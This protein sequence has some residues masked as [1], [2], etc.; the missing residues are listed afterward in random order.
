SSSD[1][2]KWQSRLRF[3]DISAIKGCVYGS[4]RDAC[5]MVLG[6][7]PLFPPEVCS[8][9][10]DARGGAGGSGTGGG[11]GASGGGCSCTIA[12]PAPVAARVLELCHEDD[13]DLKQVADTIASDQA[14]C[15][16]ILRLVNSPAFGLRHQVRST[17]HAIAL[18]GLNSVRTLS[19]SCSLAREL[20]DAR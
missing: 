4:C 20:H 5:D 6:G 1:G 8:R 11:T 13:L 2:V 7:T 14:L 3:E 9:S 16:T 18:L 10:S 12:R 17:S 19:L 15:A